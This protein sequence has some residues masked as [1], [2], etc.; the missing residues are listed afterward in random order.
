[1]KEATGEFSMTVV[2]I[3]AIT[4]IAGLITFL[5]PKVATYI[6]SNWSNMT[7]DHGCKSNQVWNGS[8][9]VK[10]N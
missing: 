4:V 3:I 10:A 9:C 7:A 5:A 2:T 6:N 8:K 1:M